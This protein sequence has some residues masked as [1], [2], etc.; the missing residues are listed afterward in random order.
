MSVQK[1]E[2][3]VRK[4]AHYLGLLLASAS[5]D[6]D[7]DNAVAILAGTGAP[8]G[9]TYGGQTLAT[10]QAAVA[11][12]QDATGTDAFMYFTVNGGTNWYSVESGEVTEGSLSDAVK[13][14]ISQVAM[15]D[16]VNPPTASASKG[17]VDGSGNELLVEAQAVADLTTRIQTGG[18]TMSHL[19]NHNTVAAK[20][21]SSTH[22]IP[23]A[24]GE[25]RKD[26]LVVTA[27]GEYALRVGTEGAAPASDPT[28]TAGD[29]PLARITLTEG[30]DTTV[31]AGNITDLRERQSLD[32]SKALED[33]LPIAAIPTNLITWEKLETE[34]L[35]VKQ[36]TIATGDVATMNATPVEM[37]A[38]PGAGFYID[39]QSIHWFLD[40]AGVAYDAAAAGDTL[41]AKYTDGAGAAVCDAV[42]GDAIGA[43][44]ADY[45]TKVAPVAEVI[46]VENA[47]I[48]AHINTGEWYAAAG[49]SPLK[50]EIRYVVRPFS[51]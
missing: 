9:A 31:A 15:D 6:T 17:F 29:V 27:A 42:A 50:Y 16:S 11:I 39:V 44:A 14:R 46:P 41:E 23:V 38:A 19:G 25:Q 32:L 21:P 12:R 24:A 51:W 5:G 22:T 2:S 48:V 28:L 35:V 30:V 7:A 4:A 13:A 26:I 36:G 43:A 45:H 3:N 33:S 34:V 49:D 47:A 1:F 18:T 8:S 10:G 40:F 37:I 20:D